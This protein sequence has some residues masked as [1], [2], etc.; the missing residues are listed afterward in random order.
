MFWIKEISQMH[1]FDYW[2]RIFFFGTK[3][4]LLLLLVVVFMQHYLFQVL[5]VFWFLDFDCSLRLLDPT[6]TQIKN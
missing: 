3:M 5:I 6:D 1:F 4:L 2:L